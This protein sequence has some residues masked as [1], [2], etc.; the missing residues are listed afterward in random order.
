VYI[1]AGYTDVYCACV[2]T[3]DSV[4]R[5]HAD[6]SCR[7]FISSS[8]ARRLHLIRRL[9]ARTLLER[10]VFWLPRLEICRR[11]YTLSL[12]LRISTFR[13][14]SSSKAAHMTARNVRFKFAE[15]G[16]SSAAT[17]PRV[18]T[19]RWKTQGRKLSKISKNKMLKT[20]VAGRLPKL[21][22]WWLVLTGNIN[23]HTAAKYN[24]R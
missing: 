18:A 5:V 17:A 3:A 9:C 8:S 7:S 4:R 21:E 15:N 1:S 2:W 14:P 23:T 11:L 13:L 10:V 12:W 22:A 6:C 19:W 24:E 20:I 16:L